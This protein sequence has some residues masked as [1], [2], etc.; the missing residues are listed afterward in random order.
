MRLSKGALA[1]TALT[2]LGAGA[3]LAATIQS[4]GLR[5]TALAQV[6]PYKL[7]RTKPS[8]IA[9]FVANVPRE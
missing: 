5:I 7:A 6:K 2:L 4:E 8:P 1:L 3:A 9:V